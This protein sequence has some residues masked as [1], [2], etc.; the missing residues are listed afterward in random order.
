MRIK[1]FSCDP[2]IQGQIDALEGAVNELLGFGTYDVVW[3]QSS[4]SGSAGLGSLGG[5]GSQSAVHRLTCIVRDNRS[6]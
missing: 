2:T 1:I 4:A 6:A 5:P 3:L